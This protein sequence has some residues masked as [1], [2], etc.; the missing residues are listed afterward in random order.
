M[1]LFLFFFQS[2]YA[3][4]PVEGLAQMR[5]YNTLNCRIPIKFDR[6]KVVVIDQFEIFQDIDIPANG[7]EILTYELDYQ[8]CK[9]VDPSLRGRKMTGKHY[10]PTEE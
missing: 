6:Q 1:I 2:T 8:N 5:I 9:D 3:K 7:M 10:I 4:T